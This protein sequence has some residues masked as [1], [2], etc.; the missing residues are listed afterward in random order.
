MTL[1]VGGLKS[2]DPNCCRPA[3]Y[4]CS[5]APR[6]HAMLAVHLF[7]FLNGFKHEGSARFGSWR[8]TAVFVFIRSARRA[9]QP[10]SSSNLVP[11]LGVWW[12]QTVSREKA[13]QALPGTKKK[14][15]MPCP[16]EIARAYLS[17]RSGCSSSSPVRCRRYRDHPRWQNLRLLLRGKRRRQ[18]KAAF[19]FARR[20]THFCRT[21][22]EPE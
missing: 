7:L 9:Q 21:L 13:T 15:K 11:L 6:P 8:Q 3:A 10:A 1:I 19:H 4:G 5:A 16:R 14:K 22:S 2:M 12:R 20:Q 18:G 17:H